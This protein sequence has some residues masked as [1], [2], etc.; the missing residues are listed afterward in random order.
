MKTIIHANIDG[1]EIVLGFGEA[2][3]FI[4][5]V[6]TAIKVSP[7]LS[8]ADE[9]KQMQAV[10][11]QVNAAN[12]AAAQA[13]SLADQARLRGDIA[14]MTRQNAEYQAKLIEIADLQKQL[15]PLVTAFEAKRAE[16]T[17][18][19]AS[20]THPP[21]GEDL[22]D[23]PQATDMTKKFMAKSKTQ[24]LLLTGDYVT[25][26]RGKDFY[27][28]GPPWKH[29]VID[30]LGEELPAGAITEDIL[31]T[32]QRTQI[33]AQEEAD[34][35]AALSPADKASEAAAAQQAAKNAVT[36]VQAEV[37]AGITA[38]SALDSAVA[39]YKTQLAVIN[40]KYGTS[41]A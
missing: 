10:N 30:T 2:N 36:Q 24:Q 26:L 17:E 37:T 11:V 3:G 5:P 15:A 34:R 21:Q 40:S 18:A 4:D 28:P 22:I 23:E 20:Y 7:L 1:Q 31:T 32:D 16:L 8:A 38:K 41:L 14:T 33:A 19:N 13:Y 6:A 9:T 29:M 27:L 12:Q 39:A 25:D 35:V